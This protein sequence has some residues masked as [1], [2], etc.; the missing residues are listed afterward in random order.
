MGIK[1]Q[2]L[3]SSPTRPLTGSSTT[4]SLEGEAQSKYNKA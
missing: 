1:R 3:G 4:Y 2:S